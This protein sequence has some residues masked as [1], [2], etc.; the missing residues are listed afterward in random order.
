MAP[1]ASRI[2][3]LSRLAPAVVLAALVL[4]SPAA[5][6]ADA[7]ANDSN[8][9]AIL[10]VVA[11]DSY[12][13]LKQQ[14][15]WLGPH[16]DNPGLA[17]M[18][19]SLLLLSTQGK[20]LI[21]LDVKRP[22]GVIVTSEDGDIGVHGIL[23]VKDL[24]KLLSSLQAVTGPV[25]NDGELRRLTLPSGQDL[26]IREADG[27][28]IIGQRDQQIDLADPA[29]Y[30]NP[31]VKEFTLAVETHPSLMP[32]SLRAL[33]A[34][35]IEQMAAASAN[36]GRPVDA[37]ALRTALDSLGAIDTLTLAM[38][39]DPKANTVFLE[40]RIVALNGPNVGSTSTPLTVA[41]AAATDG[42]L[43][44]VAAHAVQPL[45]DAQARQLI[46]ILDGALPQGS[47]AMSR[48]VSTVVRSLIEAMAAAGGVDAALTVD[49]RVAGQLPL[50]TAGAHI[51]DGAKL[52]RQLK[53]LFGPNSTLPREVKAKF[54]TG[55]VGKA[56]LHT[57]TIDVSATPAAA[58]VGPAVE[59]TLAV[60]PDYAFLLH[61]GDVAAR[62][63]GLLS[64]TGKANTAVA[65]EEVPGATIALA[66]DR[67]LAYA[68]TM[69]A[70]PQAE[71]AAERAASLLET[72][73]DSGSV[74]LSTKPI[75]RG[76]ATRLTV[77]AG[78]L[79]ALKAGAAAAAPAA[80]A[81][82]AGAGGNGN[83]RRP[84]QRLPV[85]REPAGAGR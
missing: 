32:E 41:T 79:S 13:D 54:D 53:E 29:K 51:D 61:G 62:L 2:R 21:G 11:V 24:D 68:A 85:E 30:L 72:D 22:L 14:L 33:L 55:K 17:G 5:S 58:I 84:A 1:R 49:T 82:A 3:I 65:D 43:P 83:G 57:V 47:D 63:D 36:Q 16:V 45:T 12:G 56:T 18:L 25:E 4:G 64:T 38:A 28:A 27:W 81:P 60:T 67:I 10:A 35:G 80:M 39:L 75:D 52:E 9:R 69:G 76:I 70:G 8:G 73:K 20:G 78:A 48:T 15:I 50:I 46:A 34:A 44:A 31:L 19:E 6:G 37:Q 77:G 59:L 71:A 42:G 40:N 23:P 26:E 7:L 66:L 74:Q